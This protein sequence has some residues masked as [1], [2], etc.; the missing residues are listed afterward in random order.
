MFQFRHLIFSPATPMRKSLLASL[1]Y[2]EIIRGENPERIWQKDSRIGR[3]RKRIADNRTG[4]QKDSRRI[5]NGWR[6]DSRGTNSMIYPSGIILLRSLERK[7][8]RYS[9]KISLNLCDFCVVP[10]FQ[11]DYAY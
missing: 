2:R 7:I 5:A 1:Y 3:G 6:K 4:S 9:V 8:L 10:S 11:V